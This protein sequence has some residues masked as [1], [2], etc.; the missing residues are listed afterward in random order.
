MKRRILI[1]ISVMIFLILTGIIEA[2]DEQP[3]VNLCC[4]KQ[5]FAKL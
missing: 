2:S 4:L 5:T 1:V 3:L